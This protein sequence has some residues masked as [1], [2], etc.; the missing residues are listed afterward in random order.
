[1]EE[2]YQDGFAQN[3]EKSRNLS[4]IYLTHF[5]FRHLEIKTKL[6]NLNSDIIFFF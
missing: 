2:I 1:M 4:K 5:K 3:N 6:L